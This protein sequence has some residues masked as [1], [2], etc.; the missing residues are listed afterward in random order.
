MR[1]KIFS[2]LA[3]FMAC[4]M[5]GGMVTPIAN[6]AVAETNVYP[7]AHDGYIG[8]SQYV[9]HVQ[10]NIFKVQLTLET[11]A[12]STSTDI[13]M[14]ID[15]SED[16]M[17][18][19]ETSGGSAKTYF[20]NA[21]DA[22]Y[23]SAEVFL[24]PGNNPLN[25]KSTDQNRMWIIFYNGKA[26]GMDSQVIATGTKNS[27]T[28]CYISEQAYNNP[29][30]QD[31]AGK[32]AGI[33]YRPVSKLRGDLDIVVTGVAS[34]TTPITSS[35]GAFN[36]DIKAY[37]ER[38]TAAGLAAAYDVFADYSKTENIKTETNR[39][40]LYLLSNGPDY[41]RDNVHLNG[42]G[43]ASMSSSRIPQEGSLRMEALFMA[44]A[45]K[46]QMHSYGTGTETSLKTAAEQIAASEGNSYL[47]G[48]VHAPAL[49]P[50][51]YSPVSLDAHRVIID[52][53]DLPTTGPAGEQTRYIGS[54][55]IGSP[56]VPESSGT[57]ID[58]HPYT[59]PVFTSTINLGDSTD[60]F[61][62]VNLLVNANPLA[63]ADTSN[64][65][66]Y[67]RNVNN[68]GL[69]QW[70]VVTNGYN[71]F[72]VP[73]GSGVT[74]GDPAV[75]PPDNAGN[76][77]GSFGG[78]QFNGVGHFEYQMFAN[79]APYSNGYTARQ[80]GATPAGFSDA[81]YYL[82]A[83]NTSADD[84]SPAFETHFTNMHNNPFTSPLNGSGTNRRP[85]DGYNYPFTPDPTGAS[86]TTKN[87][88]IYTYA[89]A[90]G[91][92]N[93]PTMGGVRPASISSPNVGPDNV[94]P[95]K[96]SYERIA[97]NGFASDESGGMSVE[98]WSVGLFAGDM[99][100]ADGD[101][102]KP[103]PIPLGQGVRNRLYSMGTGYGTFDEE[104]TAAD[105]NYRW[106]QTTDI[107]APSATSKMQYYTDYTGYTY[108]N[109]T[110]PT[111][112]SLFVGT[113][114]DPGPGASLTTSPG[115]AAYGVNYT[116]GYGTAAMGSYGSA[117]DNVYALNY[118]P[119]ENQEVAL[120]SNQGRATE[121]RYAS[122]VW[123]TGTATSQWGSSPT[124]TE[125]WIYGSANP[126]T[127]LFGVLGYY[128][129][130][131]TFT[132]TTGSLN[133]TNNN[134]SS[135]NANTS[136]P[137]VQGGTVPY[138]GFGAAYSYIPP[139]PDVP[140]TAKDIQAHYS[141][142]IGARTSTPP[143][144]VIP[145]NNG[146]M[147][148]NTLNQDY[149]SNGDGGRSGASSVT[150]FDLLDWHE[151]T[152][153]TG[154]TTQNDDSVG[155]ILGTYTTPNKR[156][157]VWST[158]TASADMPL[159]GPGS[160][161]RDQLIYD[162]TGVNE[163]LRSE[164]QQHLWAISGVQTS[165]TTGGIQNPSGFD[166]ANPWQNKVA[167]YWSKQTFLTTARMRRDLTMERVVLESNTR[168]DN[169]TAPTPT[170]PL[171]YQKYPF[172]GADITTSNYH[173]TGSNITAY[174]TAHTLSS[175]VTWR[176]PWT[177]ET[178]TPEGSNSVNRDFQNFYEYSGFN[179]D[180]SA[181]Q[182][183]LDQTL[184]TLRYNHP[185]EA[186]DDEDQLPIVKMIHKTAPNTG[187]KSIYDVDPTEMD[188]YS[189]LER[190]FEDLTFDYYRVSS[191]GGRAI[192][193]LSQYFDFYKMPGIPEFEYRVVAEGF[194]SRYISKMGGTASYNSG[195]KKVTWTFDNGVYAGVRY[196][197][198][199][200]VTMDRETD[201][202][203]KYPFQVNS[204][205]DKFN[206]RSMVRRS[207]RENYNRY[208][209]TK[210]FP[211][212]YVY[213]IKG[214]NDINSNVV[215]MNDY[216][217]DTIDGNGNVLAS[218]GNGSAPSGEVVGAFPEG[219]GAAAA[220]QKSVPIYTASV[221]PAPKKLVDEGV[222]EGIEDVPVTGIFGVVAV[223]VV[224]GLLV[225]AIVI[226]RRAS[227]DR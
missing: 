117:S 215:I 104:I 223:A 25:S 183:A 216:T 164:L 174:A 15:A 34:K 24:A 109:H 176:Y 111:H 119:R 26:Y 165:A 205:L 150:W 21:V 16:M 101:P 53:P 13:V 125:N 52:P 179:Y 156:H 162:G 143:T 201:P 221:T 108:G 84:P 19:S 57:G 54:T 6:A 81:H 75:P 166:P 14:V 168:Y 46:L 73:N 181:Y 202:K 132:G 114:G 45:L 190:V 124:Y 59:S 155:N 2:W 147:A 173:P 175:T 191:K 44:K 159:T 102:S 131:N 188:T 224:G 39:K 78:A 58:T 199:F 163:P 149:K 64:T 140:G 47:S 141:P 130:T 195:D 10:D 133:T 169:G 9:Q 177:H 203:V 145:G 161:P 82:S 116:N 74:A 170:S 51:A 48:V 22:V 27:T 126:A 11:Y 61:Y 180:F 50:T 42:A 148:L 115:G 20:E 167:Y 40:I 99:G 94:M 185:L 110:R 151:S 208:I 37:Q 219:S 121:T 38:Y 70:G 106:E 60:P 35:D 118:E 189:R 18:R 142:N 136:W 184:T 5:F 85:L 198:S 187:K 217:P 227:I 31:Y 95:L 97:G 197:L 212:S 122:A 67:T 154:T 30:K 29:T 226:K 80:S 89:D 92:V 153:A 86:S 66:P 28:I 214:I 192:V 157:N 120:F 56:T 23:R 160:I 206:F 62:L 68:S 222:D 158:A 36:N 207:G 178:M 65:I 33:D 209:V 98:I 196:Q 200:Y 146:T 137:L 210:N 107:T 43:V 17:V 88:Y 186:Y 139:N 123:Y 4:L 135:T 69:N 79:T 76:R 55:A 213:G 194:P 103:G 204:Y 144:A 96:A 100:D 12:L 218:V 77:V 91:G 49:T 71:G 105:T 87:T 193:Q 128:H 93:D 90:V 129:A 8:L 211:S 1:K 182:T 152:G 32:T 113:G 127:P 72:V 83:L 63:S 225:V 134:Y 220:L 172:V 41:E 3:M 171:D 138:N 7:P 112:Q